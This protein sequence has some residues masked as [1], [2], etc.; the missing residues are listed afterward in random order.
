MDHIWR[1]LE[2]DLAR[3]CGPIAWLRS[4]SRAARMLLVAVL[5]VVDAW[6]FHTFMEREDIATYPAVRLVVMLSACSLLVIVAAWQVL[7]PIYR[8]ALPAWI[9]RLLV[10]ATLLLP[11]VFALLPEVPTARPSDYGLVPYDWWCLSTGLAQGAALLLLARVLDRHG[12]PADAGTMLAAAAGAML[13]MIG[14][15]VSCPINYPIHLLTG[16]ATMPAAMVVA[17]WLWHRAAR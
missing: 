17:A 14:L 7:R 10:A 13:G 12:Q 3:E 1:A 2:A 4:R 9:P 15:V 6:F 5:G 16:H 11:I 8:P